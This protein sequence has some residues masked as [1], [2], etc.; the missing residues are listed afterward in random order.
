MMSAEHTDNDDHT[1]NTWT[2]N[3]EHM[4]DDECWTHC[5]QVLGIRDNLVRIWTSD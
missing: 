4:N 5:K 1:L 3:A 2:I